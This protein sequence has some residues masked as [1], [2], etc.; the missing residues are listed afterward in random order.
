M[1]FETGQLRLFA[2]AE[3]FTPTEP[4]FPESWLL[5]SYRSYSSP[6]NYWLSLSFH[7]NKSG[8]KVDK[9][10]FYAAWEEF[11]GEFAAASRTKSWPDTLGFL[12]AAYR[13]FTYPI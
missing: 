3:P 9:E 10:K 13:D 8:L 11:F 4:P 1:L 7:A 2:E 5:D 6:W 12:K